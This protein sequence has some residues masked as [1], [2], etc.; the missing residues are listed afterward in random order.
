MMEDDDARLDRELAEATEALTEAENA[1]SEG[2]RA[3]A[4][5][6]ASR[7][8]PPST[9]ALRSGIMP[10]TFVVRS[11][12]TSGSPNIERREALR[13]AIESTT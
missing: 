11:N 4:Q 13:E 8:N 5:L 6:N 10:L 9:P 1:V 3:A 2:R 12:G 7:D